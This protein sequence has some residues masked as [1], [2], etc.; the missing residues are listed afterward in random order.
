MKTEF[1]IVSRIVYGNDFY[2]GVRALLVDKDNRP[3]WRP[4]SL[5]DVSER[6]V[7]RHFAPIGDA[8]VLP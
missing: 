3:H 1:R 8:L 4:S 5:A 6:E 7:D 2:E